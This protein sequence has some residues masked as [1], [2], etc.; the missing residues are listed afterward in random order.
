MKR[1]N[2]KSAIAAAGLLVSVCVFAGNVKWLENFNDAKDVAKKENKY[3]LADFT[4]SDWCPWCIKLD[5]EVFAKAEFKK[6]ADKNLV[7]F[8]AD[9]PKKKVQAVDTK[10]QN[11]R[12]MDEYQVYGFPTVLLM[13]AGGEVVF[14]TGYQ[15]GGSKPYIKSLEKAISDYKAKQAAAEKEKAKATLV[16]KGESDTAIKTDL[17]AC[18]TVTTS[19][20]ADT[21]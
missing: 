17:S 1:M 4:G 2:V 10:D 20:D 3:I 9:F 14:T 18:N 16:I 15:E 11:V 8:K 12:L 19:C 6:Y 21:K 13:T 5:K 7:L